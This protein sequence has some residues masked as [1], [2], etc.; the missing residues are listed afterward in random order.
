MSNTTI[1][2]AN[3]GNHRIDHLSGKMAEQG[4]IGC[5]FKPVWHYLGAT[6][7]RECNTFVLAPTQKQFRRAA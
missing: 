1:C 7:P 6:K 4:L 5:S 2:C 3:C